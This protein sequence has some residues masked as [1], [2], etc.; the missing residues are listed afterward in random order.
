MTGSLQIKKDIYYMVLNL[1][2]Q[3]GKRKPKWISTGYSVK[4]NKK[5][6]EQ[7]LRETLREWEQRHS[8]EKTQLRF[9][10]WIREWLESVRQRVDIITYEGYESTAQRHILPYFDASSAKLGEVTRPMLQVFID[11]KGIQGRLDG[12]GGLSPASIRHIRNILNQ[13]L[14]AAQQNDWI[15]TNPCDGLRLPKQQKPEFA[16][17]N[18]EQLGKLFAAIQDEPLRPLIRVTA[19]YGLRKSEVLGLQWD[20][21]DFGANTLTIKHTVVKQVSL[22]VKDKTKN[23]ASRRTFPLT[24]EIR[25]LLLQAKEDE[26]VNRHL[27]GNAY[28]ESPQIFKW[29][30]GRPYTPNYV[31]HKFSKLLEQYGLPH[32][33]FHEL[34][35]SCASLL[36]AQGFSLKDVQEWLGHADITLTANTY[37]HLD[38]SRKKRIAESISG[39]F[40][41]AC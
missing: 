31:S 6:A 5:R 39:S 17:Y 24:P 28:T 38:L 20:S 33:R 27:M 37:S 30:D 25:T 8:N 2:G 4:G 1:Y 19:V 10:D 21:V 12:T 22:V 29:P 18:A 16:F 14:K 35:H 3:D 26:A 41:W 36:I 23:A 9:S 34:R 15:A 7:M 32:I 40:T 11:Q 13:S